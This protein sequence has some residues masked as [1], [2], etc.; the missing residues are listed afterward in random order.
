M[1]ILPAIALL[2]SCSLQAEEVKVAFNLLTERLPKEKVEIVFE[3]HYDSG[4]P[5]EIT[6]KELTLGLNEIAFQSPVSEEDIG[7][8]IRSAEFSEVW[9][10][11]D[12]L[13]DEVI[14]TQFLFLKR[15]I[16]LEY[17]ISEN[18]TGFGDEGD[19]H[20]SHWVSHNADLPVMSEDFM[21]H[22]V[23]TMFTVNY[24]RVTTGFGVHPTDYSGKEFESIDH[25]P[26]GGYEYKN[27]IIEI[28]KP[29]VFR[30]CGYP[31][32]KETYVK[33]IAKEMKLEQGGA[34]NDE[35]A[36]SSR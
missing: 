17:V 28:G 27:P 1:R 10:W 9:N 11:I 25:A 26:E 20:K 15:H 14:E 5:K 24:H 34:I 35:A 18:G 31:E 16:H 36:A 29:M 22:Q 12:I 13:K 6:R 7:F 3:A 8:E 32:R 19:I 4:P 21:I 2:L 33:L 30:I 23:A